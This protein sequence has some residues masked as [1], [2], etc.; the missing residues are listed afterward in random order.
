MHARLAMTLAGRAAE[1]LVF[2]ELQRRRGERPRSS[3]TEAGAEDGHPLGHERADSAPWRYH[4]GAM[5]TRFWAARSCR[6]PT[7]LQRAHRSADRR[8]SVTRILHAAADRAQRLLSEKRAQLESI[9]EALLEREEI[10][11]DELAELI[12]PPAQ[13]NR[14][15]TTVITAD[16]TAVSEVNVH[17]SGPKDQSE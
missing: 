4:N 2:N 10:D 12:G 8:G 13:D 7:P 9:T 6:R 15:P 5:T 1:K 14:P 17:Q 16:A 3:A 11:E